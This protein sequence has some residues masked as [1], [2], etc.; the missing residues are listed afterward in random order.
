[1]AAMFISGEG[2]IVLFLFVM[3]YPQLVGH[4][5]LQSISPAHPGFQDDPGRLNVDRKDSEMVF[6]NYSISW[7]IHNNSRST[8]VQAV[9]HAS[10]HP[11]P[12]LHDSGTILLWSRPKVFHSI[13]TR[14]F[15]IHFMYRGRDATSLW[16][17]GMQP[18]PSILVVIQ[19]TIRVYQHLL[20]HS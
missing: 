5:R 8:P 20:R 3:S 14:A 19:P 18:R 9:R 15:S 7:S 10:M 16:R 2:R 11:C 12:G 6:Q 17:R 13:P 1:M 4:V